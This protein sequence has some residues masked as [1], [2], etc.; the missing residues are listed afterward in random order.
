MAPDELRADPE[1]RVLEIRRYRDVSEPPPGPR[2]Q[3]I[4]ERLI[5]LLSQVREFASSLIALSRWARVLFAILAILTGLVWALSLAQVFL[6]T[7]WSPLFHL[8]YAAGSGGVAIICSLAAHDP[9]TPERL[10]KN[11]DACFRR[12]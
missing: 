11:L 3:P 8:A 9:S 12:K 5:G 1:A 6:S 7:G 2:P 10:G 4:R